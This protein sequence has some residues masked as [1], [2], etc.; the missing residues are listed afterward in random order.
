M[1][2]E[3]LRLIRVFHDLKQNH[4]SG[5]LG[6]SASYLSEI[7]SGTKVPNLDLLEKYS[8]RFGIPVSSIMLF[9]ESLGQ[10]SAYTKRL[11]KVLAGKTL[12]LMQW[13]ETARP[14]IAEHVPH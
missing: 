13:I 7:E 10:E 9:S 8:I 6:I 14:E 4:L 12:A 2:N 5:E 3:A 11:R 1:I